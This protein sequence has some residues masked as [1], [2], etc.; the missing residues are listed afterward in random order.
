M[1]FEVPSQ[2]LE[3]PNYLPMKMY[4]L[5][6]D[7]ATQDLVASGVTVV[8]AAEIKCA[9]WREPTRQEELDE[10]YILCPGRPQP[11]QVKLPESMVVTTLA[12]PQIPRLLGEVFIRKVM[13]HDRVRLVR[14]LGQWQRY[15]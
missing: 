7:D 2:C 11:P 6:C 10:G 13:G 12:Y 5:E 4:E 14:K 15:R 1:S 8:R 9:G 3:C